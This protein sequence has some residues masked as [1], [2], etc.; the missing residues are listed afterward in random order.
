MQA[1]LVEGSKIANSVLKSLQSDVLSCMAGLGAESAP[2]LAVL[3]ISDRGDS[4][5]FLSQKQNMFKRMSFE[6]KVERVQAGCSLS[7]LLHRIDL[8]NR[9]QAVH[10]IQIYLPLPPNLKPFGRAI[11]DAISPAKDVEGLNSSV[12]SRMQAF[13]PTGDICAAGVFPC[14]FKSTAKVLQEYRVQCS[15]KKAVVLGNS[16]TAGQPIGAALR[17][18]GAEVSMVDKRVKQPERIIAEADIVVSAVGKTDIFDVGLLRDGAVVLD[19]GINLTQDKKVRGDLDCSKLLSRASLVSQVP[20]GMGPITS[21]MV[22]HNLYTLWRAQ[23]L[24][25]KTPYG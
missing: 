1:R 17:A 15:N 12:Y 11:F 23:I 7:E 22:L 10:G 4:D 8:L 3:A 21:A 13:D 18:F 25:S 9:D 14:T 16:Y 2:Q 20:G 6:M 19:F 5:S 24:S